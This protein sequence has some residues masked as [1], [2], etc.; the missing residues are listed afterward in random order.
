MPFKFNP[1][2]NKLDNVDVSSAPPAG[3]VETLEGNSGGL[4][5][6]V[7][8][9]INTIG[10]GSIT[11]AGSGNTLTTQLTGLT[12]HSVQ[13]GSGTSTL[14]QIPVATNGQVL[15]GAT[16]AD[17]AFATLTS[18]D[19]SITFTPGANS[20]SLQV[21][22][23][24]T[25]G[26]TI[27]GQGGGALAPVAGNW[28][29]FGNNGTPDGFASYT[30]G[31]GNTLKVNSYGTAKW[32]VNPT[33]N[34]GTHQTITAALAS[35]VSGETIFVTPGTY[36]ENITLKAGVNIVAYTADAYTP[37]VTITGKVT[38]TAAGTATLSGLRL[39]SNGD[40]CIEVTGANAVNLNIVGC[41][42]NSSDANAVHNTN[43][44]AGITLYQC[45]G[46]CSTN[47]FFVMTAGGITADY[48]VLAGANTT[49]NSTV[50]GGSLVLNY[51]YMSCPITTSGTGAVG[52]F[53]TQ[54]VCANTIALTHGGSGS[55]TAQNSR[56]EA[57]TQ[58][59]VSIGATLTMVHCTVDST[60][61]AAIAGAGNLKYG[62]IVFTNSSSTVSTST[63]TP[64]ATLI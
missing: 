41:Y 53:M 26:K 57:G 12:N 47:T 32:V 48:C 22:G 29:I 10:A 30:T 15:L 62:L 1:F 44:S 61:A 16:G 28:F 18:S 63:V 58:S 3:F 14:T 50:S 23:G 2:T 7:G 17:P 24:T 34:I 37:T 49:T 6:P 4:I 38:M 27:T 59:A 64:L 35:A 25:S 39:Q 5:S 33:V 55:S 19:G 60:N 11:I 8:G 36:T 43:S 31:S 52:L 13:V 40:Y 56:F 54:L 42:L 45:F 51:S 20:L 21:A 46:N 9:N